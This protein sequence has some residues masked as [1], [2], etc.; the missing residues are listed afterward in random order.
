VPKT[1]PF[2]LYSNPQE[3]VRS[4]NDGYSYW[5]GK[6][7]EASFALSL[8]VIGAN[9]AVF[10]SVDRILGNWLA[11]FSIAAAILNLAISL[12]GSERLGELL[13]RRINYAEENH[14]RW[15][16]EFNQS[17]GQATPWPFTQTI[18]DV[19]KVSRYAKVAL[20]IIGGVL[21]GIAL[22]TQPKVETK[23]SQSSRS[24]LATPPVPLTTPEATKQIATMTPTP[25]NTPSSSATPG[26]SSSP[27]SPN[28]N[29]F[30]GRY[31]PLAAAL[32]PSLIAS[33]SLTYLPFFVL[34]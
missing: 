32:S 10:G 29:G 3:A 16:N 12:I 21:F 31:C 22:F 4:V 17:V 5:T 7:T 33:A 2:G 26:A 6:L 28:S 34:P 30:D 27:T 19:A 15:Q 25:N 20:P 1:N 18:D 23:E 9:W 13:R 24:S 8:A 14:P 11:E